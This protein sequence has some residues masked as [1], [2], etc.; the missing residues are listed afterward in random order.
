VTTE[1]PLRWRRLGV[2]ALLL[3][4]AA[5]YLWHITIN[6][7]GNAFYAAATQSG[8]TNW[9]A[10]LFG[11]LDPH[12]F[13]TVD[14]PPLS[15]WVMGLSGRLFGFGSASMLVPEALMAIGTVALLYAAVA[16]V[17]GPRAGLLAGTAL[18]LTPVAVLMFR[19]N[20][21]D[22]AMVLLMTAA[23]YCTLRALDP[24]S[25]AARW[26]VLA[27]V[28]LG[29]AFLAKMLEGLLIA[30][31]LAATYLVA[32]PVPLRTRLGHLAAAAA[33]M[34]A[35]GGWFILLAT[36]WPA[37]SRPYLAGS[38]DNDFMNL[39]LGYN[40]MARILGR[41]HEVAIPELA[42]VPD[43]GTQVHGW[44]RLLSGEFAY[45]IG[46]LVPASVV[47]VVVVVIARGRAPRTDRVRAATV[48]FGGWLLVDGLV[49]SYMHGTVH[50][51]YSLSIAP[52]VAAM[53]A[54]GLQQTWVRRESL[55]Y[56]T[57]F[58]V[59]SLGTG[60]WSWWV[61][62]RNAHWLPPLRWAV[63]AV[64][65]LAAVAAFGL[66][67][68]RR[69]VAATAAATVAVAGAL[70]GSGAY[71]FATAVTPHHGGGPSVGPA[72][73]GVLTAQ[74]ARGVVDPELDALLEATHTDWSAAVDRS[75][76]AAALELA[77]QT[78]VMA[79]GGF[80]GLDPTP[81]LAQFQRDVA[82]HRVAYYVATSTGSQLGRNAPSHN[83]IA[84]WVAFNY[85]ARRVGTN[86][87]FDLTVPPREP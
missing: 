59:M 33:A 6:G 81:T 35:S 30:P 73:R 56:Q 50:A 61:L 68:A 58:V 71:A 7:M 28:A 48:L 38:T 77:T 2:C 5:L 53:F 42:D 64:A 11:S 87:I 43:L 36:W 22:A 16:R 4:T 80:S 34:V 32:A 78:A 47:A 15:L 44:S 83:D 3:G 60:V 72:R 10:L 14:K 37:S 85:V 27:G 66:P 1:N 62:G 86:V 24:S 76:N 57:G 9:K 74:R 51:Y 54:I 29:L 25:R 40:G 18:A 70:A 63:L 52:A 39:V 49:L 20:N 82:E 23:A 19:Y 13:I 45:E 21:P 12:N 17:C 84:R 65:A 26:V 79:I 31:A 55:S 8:S 75:S 67:V 46:W 69:H 41:N